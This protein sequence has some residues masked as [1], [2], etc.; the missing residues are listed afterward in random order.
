MAKVGIYGHGLR[1]RS[2]FGVLGV[3][4]GPG[5]H[6]LELRRYRCLGCNAVLVVGPWDLVP[7]MLYGLTTV[8]LAL[9]QWALGSTRASVRAQ[10]GAFSVIGV[11]TRGDWPSLRRWACRAAEGHLLMKVCVSLT[12]TRRQRSAR[13][14]HILAGAGPPEGKLGTRALAGAKHFR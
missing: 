5:V 14:I 10:F 9:A 6:E 7:G 4:E 3:G 12:G 2:V 1:R 8:V 11:S 13:W